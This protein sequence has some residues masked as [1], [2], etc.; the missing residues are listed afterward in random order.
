M[1]GEVVCE[2]Y[3]ALQVT[4]VFVVL[5]LLLTFFSVLRKAGTNLFDASTSRLYKSRSNDFN[6]LTLFSNTFLLKLVM[7]KLLDSIIS[8]H[9]Y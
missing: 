1:A 5:S 6:K 4:C 9:V 3:L 2:S 7:V 8:T